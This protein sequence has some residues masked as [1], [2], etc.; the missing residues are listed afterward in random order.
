M[1]LR[2]AGGPVRGRGIRGLRGDP[3]GRQFLLDAASGLVPP[4][5]TYTRSGPALW[6][7]Q[8]DG[9]LASFAANVLPRSW[10]AGGWGFEFHPGWTN[11]FANQSV[12]GGL[13]LGVGSAIGLSGRP[14]NKATVP[15][16]T[17]SYAQV[18]GANVLAFS[19]SAGQSVD[20]SMQGYVGAPIGPMS[21]G[22]QVVSVITTGASSNATYSGFKISA[23]GVVSGNFLASGVSEIEP[24]VVTLVAPGLWKF[25]WLLRYTQG[26]TIRDTSR[27]YLEVLNSAGAASNVVGDGVSAVQWELCQHALAGYHPPIA[28]TTTTF[29]TVGTN[30]MAA[31]LSA[32]E[33]TLGSECGLGVEAV[34]LNRTAGK[35]PSMLALRTAAA[36]NSSTTAEFFINPGPGYSAVVK[37]AGV[38]QFAHYPTANTPTRFA[39]R[40]KANDFRAAFSG[41]LS[42]ADTSGSVPAFDTMNVGFNTP[43][44]TAACRITRAY[45][46][47]NR[48]PSDAELAAMTA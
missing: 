36:N 35:F 41:A 38:E 32:L 25:S 45:L 31:T 40:V 42:P 10:G 43:T 23:T 47:P 37:S 30:N 11:S 16:G 24:P 22:V 17:F 19:V 5:F 33:I 18:G 7:P 20:I 3:Y 28:D 13:T 4:G 8:Q 14:L 2:V 12:G 26:A 39:M 9:S 29:G 6:L 48:A 46:I 27:M 15:A 44:D 21:L 34:A 1:V